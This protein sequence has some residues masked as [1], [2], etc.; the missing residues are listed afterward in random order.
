MII[1]KTDVSGG[2]M[3]VM[4]PVFVLLA[5]VVTLVPVPAHADLTI[6]PIRILMEGRDRNSDLTIVNT[7]DTV[8]TYRLEWRHRRMRE[9]GGYEHLDAPLDPLFDPDE[10]IK[11]SPR[12]VTIAPGQTQRIRLSLRKPA[13]LPD[14]EYRAH[15]V[16]KKVAGAVPRR[17]A[18]SSGLAVQVQTNVG[19]SI[20][21]VV[22][23]G[24]YDGAVKIGNPQFV[25]P[26]RPEHL[27]HLTL[28]VHR[29]GIHSV[30][31]TVRVYWTPEGEKE[32][33]VGQAKNVNV[34]H[35]I[36]KRIV[37]VTMREDGITSGAIRITFE[38]ANERK[39]LLYDE[40][41]FPVGQ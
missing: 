33:L 34:F 1:K 18:P 37:G 12:N 2:V 22:R 30:N 11:F 35:E 26:A 25:Q 3:G 40:Q 31:G 16:L 39:G 27:P 9:V 41:V 6:L 21:V 29:T 20:P 17:E 4:L 10:T 28:D 14:G 8:N 32:R 5:M 24:G 7:S 38:G 23:Q 36:D 19:F 15:L 13:D